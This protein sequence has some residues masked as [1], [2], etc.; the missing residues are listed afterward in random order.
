MVK[1]HMVIA[2]KKQFCSFKNPCYSAIFQFRIGKSSRE[3]G[4]GESIQWPKSDVYL[5][6][7]VPLMG[8]KGGF[9][10]M[11]RAIG[12]QIEKTT[13]RE[14]C[15]DLS[16]RRLRD[17]NEEKRL[18][19]WVAKQADREKEREERKQKK[20][21]KLKEEFHH[22]FHDPEYY[23]TRSEVT[24][25]VH[26]ALE[27]GLEPASTSAEPCIK[28][29]FPEPD[30]C[31][32]KRIKRLD[33]MWMG[34][35]DSDSDSSEDGITELTESASPS[36]LTSA[37]EKQT[38]PKETETQT[39]T[40]VIST[41]SE[42]TSNEETEKDVGNLDAKVSPAYEPSAEPVVKEAPPKAPVTAEPEVFEPINLDTIESEQELEL[43]GLAHIKQELQ[44]RGLKCGGSLSER[45]SRLFS[46]K[47]LNNDQ[48]NPKLFSKPPKK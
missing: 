19:D 44:S 36:A 23:K 41:D 35:S 10:S 22:V 45:A 29:K 6:T 4:P 21:E 14:A 1:Q 33:A 30:S 38:I 40:N 34:V 17:I 16:G 42:T 28:R 37:S 2:K 31:Q 9:G 15:R 24:D 8:G 25:K 13:N 39:E 11:L 43:L 32:G 5:K 27:K 20:M 18:K 26:A 48:I 7:T 47:G 3:I 12:A 46:V